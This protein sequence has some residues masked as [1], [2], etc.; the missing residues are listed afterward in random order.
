MEKSGLQV[1][2]GTPEAFAAIVRRDYDKYGTALRSAG[3]R[4]E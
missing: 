3:V 4:P 2:G 1:S